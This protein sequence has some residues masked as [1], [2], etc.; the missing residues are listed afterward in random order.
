MLLQSFAATADSGKARREWR[1]PWESGP[2]PSI[3]RRRTRGRWLAYDVR[4]QARR[5]AGGRE[6]H[7]RFDREAG[8]ESC[9][10]LTTRWDVPSNAARCDRDRQR[11]EVVTR[12][13]CA[14]GSRKGERD[15]R[16]SRQTRWRQWYLAARPA[17]NSARPASPPLPPMPPCP[18]ERFP[19]D[20]G[21]RYLAPKL[22]AL[23]GAARTAAP[24]A[25]T[26]ERRA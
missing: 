26:E 23:F 18:F 7:D 24:A 25:R 21:A 15:P 9:R 3:S 12:C 8:G 13:S 19:H 17:D 16:V 11:G 22:A 14:S 10:Y 20:C 4:S 1:K 6:V 2:P 5:R